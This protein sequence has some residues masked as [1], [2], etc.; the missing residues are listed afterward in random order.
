MH[1]RLNHCSRSFEGKQKGDIEYSTRLVAWHVAAW[2][3]VHSSIV[4]HIIGLVVA[5]HIIQVDQ[6]TGSRP[7]DSIDPTTI[8]MCTGG[9]ACRHH[10]V[11]IMITNEEGSHLAQQGISDHKTVFSLCSTGSLSRQLQST[12]AQSNA[13]ACLSSCGA[14]V[15]RESQ[16]Y[17]QVSVPGQPQARPRLKSVFAE[18]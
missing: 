16:G 10:D 18:V 11:M 1:A 12:H 6:T 13:G 15:A 14:H 2:T 5:P 7:G 3:H 9:S 8:V 4:K 17:Q